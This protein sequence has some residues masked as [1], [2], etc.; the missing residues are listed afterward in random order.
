[1]SIEPVLKPRPTGPHVNGEVVPHRVRAR[2]EELKL[3]RHGWLDGK[4][5][6]PPPATLDWVA[7]AFEERYPDDLRLPYLFPTPAGRVLAEWSLAPWALSL[8]IDPG[9]RRGDWHALN[10]DTDEEVE[11]EL[12]LSGAGDWEWLTGQVRA[13]GGVAE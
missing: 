2:V 13:A 1:M 3:L 12:D 7:A 8:D 9:A 6:A 10:L 11:K 5:L 4:G